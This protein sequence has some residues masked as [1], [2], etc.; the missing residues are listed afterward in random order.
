M[1]SRHRRPRPRRGV[2]VLLAAVLMVVVLGMLAFAVDIGFIANSRAE[3]QNVADAAALA[4]VGKLA[5]QLRKAPIL[6]GTPVQTLQDLQNARD[7][8]IAFAL[9]NRI[10][11]QNAEVK[12]AEVEIG[13]LAN[14][15]DFSNNTLDTS[16]WPARP[17]NA[18]RVSVTRDSNHAGGPLEL[19]FGPV[20]GVR[21]RNINAT[22]TA[23]MVMGTVIPRGNNGA[24]WGGLLPFTYQ[25][26]EWNALL[27]AT[28]TGSITVTL[29]NTTTT[30]TLTDDYSLA[31]GT[32]GS[33]SD[34][35]LE[36]D[37]FP[38][39]TT[40]GNFGTINFTTGKSG[41]S[42]STLRDLILNGPAHADWPDLPSIVVASMADP[43]AI[44]GDPGI[45]AGMESAV[46]S[47]V[48]QPRIIPLYS[49]VSGTGNNSMYEIVGFAPITIVD[50]K[51]KG[52]SK[53][54]RIQPRVLSQKE[55]LSGSNRITFDI[56]PSA[57]PNP[58][59]LGGRV[60]AR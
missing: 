50:V 28:S 51:L 47:V 35:K 7:E 15:A 17:Y 59:F 49:T 48:G 56:T 3:A 46:T 52:G 4:G 21:Q 37:L 45:S 18:V 5:E 31:S 27:A 39:R 19:F 20:L 6:D 36:T 42:T 24:V 16:G 22:A 8:A 13:Y 2:I 57:T 29:P 9:K 34:G 53:Y 30:M 55:V 25:V 14:P 60:L 12:T 41:N 23:V 26:D 43:V 10:A 44:N 32:V 58:L 1:L 11:S 38:D 54:I 40:A 33:E